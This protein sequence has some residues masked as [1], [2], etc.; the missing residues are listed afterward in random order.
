MS[1]NRRTTLFG[2]ALSFAASPAF[3]QT[4]SPV[5]I[6]GTIDAVKNGTVV[7]KTRSGDER[8][9]K[10]G[11]KVTYAWVVPTPI[12]AVKSG[13]FIGT[14]AINEPDGTLKALEIHVFPEAMRGSGEGHRGWDLG[15]NSSMTNGTVGAVTQTD[16]RTLHLSYKGGEKIVHVPPGTPI[17][18]FE[19]GSADAI[20]KP[21]DHV[22]VTAQ[23]GNDGSLTATSIRGGKDGMVPPM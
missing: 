17:V 11:D 18:T 12:S 8:S 4:T 7:L 1:L 9:V 14:A 19:P 3:A 23:Q 20:L 10:L 21:G 16:G 13:A 22:I 6:R 15:Q 5:R 2:M